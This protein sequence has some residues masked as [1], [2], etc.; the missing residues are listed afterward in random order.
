MEALA[1][2]QFNL[3]KCVDKADLGGRGAVAGAT[4]LVDRAATDGGTCAL[5]CL[6]ETGTSSI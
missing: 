1:F 4:L 6:V 3:F 2:V 5:F